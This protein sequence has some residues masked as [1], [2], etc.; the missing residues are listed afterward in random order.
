MPRG[1][2]CLEPGRPRQPEPATLSTET[3]RCLLAC[4]GL[5]PEL[6]SLLAR[7]EGH[8]K[9][10]EVARATVQE[11]GVLEAL[12]ASVGDDF[13]KSG[14]SS[15][16][17]PAAR[18][19]LLKLKLLTNLSLVL[20]SEA[21]P[22]QCAA[23][24]ACC[25]SVLQRAVSGGAGRWVRP[26]ERAACLALLSCFLHRAQGAV[27]ARLGEVLGYLAVLAGLH[28]TKEGVSLEPTNLP[29]LHFTRTSNSEEQRELAVC[30]ETS[31]S[32][33]SDHELISET[34]FRIK[35]VEAM[36]QR[37]ALANLGVIAKRFPKK[38][39]VSFWF[40]F[41]PDSSYSP[42]SSSLAD[43]AVH[44]SKKTRYQALAILTDFVS[45]SAQFL[46]LAQQSS[47]PSSYTSLS[48]ALAQALLSLHRL[49]LARLRESLGP[50][51][52]VALLKLVASLTENCSYSR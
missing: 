25:C 8:C 24:L 2:A 30:P 43:L 3:L 46:A 21:R 49:V 32:E 37:D 40:L 48:T 15:T 18:L 38:D 42:L 5:A 33:L 7:L 20:V 45:H 12:L 28:P 23:V 51:E 52:M 14:T 22:E 16:S 29:H 10:Q 34:E 35:R 36:V 27:V 47:K 17:L 19:R 6:G 4:E 50:T 41:L 9:Q 11:S 1:G 26:E 39:V 44:Y 31:E 13:S